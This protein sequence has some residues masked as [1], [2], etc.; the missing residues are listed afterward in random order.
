MATAADKRKGRKRANIALTLPGA[1]FTTLRAIVR[2]PS[3]CEQNGL[4]KDNSAT[5]VLHTISRA[6]DKS[7]ND[8]L[9]P[10][11]NASRQAA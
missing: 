3:A 4:V 1:I 11:N 7:I 6:L 8:K 10:L 2:T 9:T 5:K